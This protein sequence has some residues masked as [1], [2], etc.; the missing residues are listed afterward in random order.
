MIRTPTP[1]ERLA[2]E[3]IAARHDPILR[4]SREMCDTLSRAGGE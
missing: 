3:R 1:W 2:N 4:D